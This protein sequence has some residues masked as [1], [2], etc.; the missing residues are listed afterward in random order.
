MAGYI[1]VS[2]Q[3]QS[4]QFDQFTD[5]ELPSAWLSQADLNFSQF[6]VAYTTGPAKRQRRIWSI[7]AYANQT[8]VIAIN[9]LFSAWDADREL[10]TGIT[11]VDVEDTLLSEVDAGSVVTAKAFF[12]TPPQITKISG[13]NNTLFTVSFGLTEVGY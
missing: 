4:V 5:E 8:K 2:F 12:T 11:T 3:N 7:A 6:G 13:A 1:E 10:N 9:D